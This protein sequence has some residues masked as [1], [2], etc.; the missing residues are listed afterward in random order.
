MEIK[1]IEKKVASSDGI[2]QLAGR[3]Y[4]PDSGIRGI[5]HVVHGMIEHIASALTT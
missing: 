3:V 2:H 5:F 1:I 4:V